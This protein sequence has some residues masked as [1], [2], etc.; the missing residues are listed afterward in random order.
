[1]LPSNTSVGP[2]SLVVPKVAR[3][4]AFYENQL[5]FQLLSNAEGKATL[6]TPDGTVLLE[7]I[8]DP[9]TVRPSR[10]APGLF[11][12]AVLFP[13]RVALGRTLVHFAETGGRLSGAGDHLV[14]E[15]LYLDD[16]DGNGIE[17]YQDRPRETWQFDKGM[18]L[19][20][21]LPVDVESLIGEAQKDPSPWTG[22]PN[23][24]KIGHV[25]LKVN[26]IEQAGHFYTDVIGFD[27]MATMPQALFV[28]AGGY[29]HHLGL[30]TWMSEGT[31]PPPPGSSGLNGFVINLPS[32]EEREEVL[33]RLTA[34][35]FDVDYSGED[36]FVRDPAQNGVWL[37][38]VPGGDF[39]Q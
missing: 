16:P 23:G 25:H 8:E 33:E 10:R 1:M 18:V 30:N 9:T 26:D 32:Q 11:H 35:G 7:L 38:V 12:F 36:P 31:P 27:L 2:V 28:S 21:T 24:T 19:M 22:I 29:H 5:G 17:L 37:K 20:D 13:S 39:G 3:S 6:G 14:S 15:A 34:A 4:L